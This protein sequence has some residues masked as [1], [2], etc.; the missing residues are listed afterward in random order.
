MVLMARTGLLV[1]CTLFLLPHA[2]AIS[3]DLLGQGRVDIAEDR[4]ACAH[5]HPGLL[6]AATLQATA[7]ADASA[8]GVDVDAAASASAAGIAAGALAH[9]DADADGTHAHVL[10]A[11][12][13]AVPV[14]V[15]AAGA[16]DDEPGIAAYGEAAGTPVGPVQIPEEQGILERIG[17]WLLSWF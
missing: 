7:C 13:G 12:D 5:V 17:S 3:I 11:S 6:D 14:G 10:A 2:S 16:I 4:L 1:L 8:D 15:A 9:A